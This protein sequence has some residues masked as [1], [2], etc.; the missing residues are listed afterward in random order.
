MC[1]SEKSQF[2]TSSNRRLHIIESGVFYHCHCCYNFLVRL[3]CCC[4]HG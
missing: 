3:I 2:A 4:M 1:T